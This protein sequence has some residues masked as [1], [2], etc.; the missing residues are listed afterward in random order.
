MTVV[1]ARVLQSRIRNVDFR[2]FSYPF[3]PPSEHDDMAKLGEVVKVHDGIAYADKVGQNVAF[4]YFK[5]AEVLYGDVDGDGQDDAAV[6]V[7]YGNNAGTFYLTDIYIY[8]MK[9]GEP[10]LLSDLKEDQVNKDYR[11]YYHDDGQHIFEAVEGGRE[12]KGGI[13]TVK[14]LADGAHCCPQQVATLQYRLEGNR[15]ILVGAPL[16]RSSSETDQKMSAFY[17]LR[18]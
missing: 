2:N 1:S 13:L 3:K 10:V 11:K 12:V 8:G 17:A 7:I 4:W 6:V 15:L 18:N 16:K 5:V 9:D 14:H